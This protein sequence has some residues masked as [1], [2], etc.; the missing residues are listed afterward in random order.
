MRSEEVD[1]SI[2]PAKTFL[3][4]VITVF[5]VKIIALNDTWMK[6]C[7]KY[8]ESE[9]SKKRNVGVIISFEC[10]LSNQL[11]IEISKKNA[12]PL[13]RTGDLA[14]ICFHNRVREITNGMQLPTVLEK[15]ES[16]EKP[17]IKYIN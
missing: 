5:L 8:F 4:L 3:L 17:K 16:R 9:I 7:W 11:Q 15:H 13:D 10:T 14:I 12:S 6:I 1:G 2:P